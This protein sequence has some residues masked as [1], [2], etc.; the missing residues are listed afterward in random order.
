LVQQEPQDKAM[1]VAVVTQIQVHLLTA[2]AVVLVDRVEMEHLQ[3]HLLTFGQVEMVVQVLLLQLQE[4]RLVAQAVGAAQQ[5]QD[6]LQE[7]QYWVQEVQVVE[8]QAQ[9]P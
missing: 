6:K 4:H 8:T 3:V 7:L 9:L 1:Q 2:V 5:I